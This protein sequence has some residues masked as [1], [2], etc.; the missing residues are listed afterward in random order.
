MI[1]KYLGLSLI[2]ASV[3]VMGCS[4]SDDGPST[5]GGTEPEVMLV[6]VPTTY[7]PTAIDP[8][9]T[10]SIAALATNTP[11]LSTLATAVVD[12]GLDTALD[13]ASSVF[14]V[15]APTNDAFALVEAGKLDGLTPEALAEVLNLHVVAGALDA[16]AV[17]GGVGMSVTTAEGTNLP[18]TADADGNLSIGGAPISATNIYATN[19]IVHLI[20]AVILPAETGGGDTSM[21]GGDDSMT[22][23]D[24]STT[25]GDAVGAGEAALEAAGNTSFIGAFE[26]IGLFNPQNFTDS[27][28]TIFAPTNDAIAAAGSVTKA[29]IDNHIYTNAAPLMAADFIDGSTLDMFGGG[30]YAVTNDGTTIT[31]GGFTVTEVY[32]GTAIIYSIDGVLQ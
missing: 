19:G 22:G 30:S 32:N 17:A 12:A 10:L 2:T 5:T 9:P 20:D 27:P 15:F 8:V 21:T 16:A 11:A 24:D 25:G 31:V 23:G 26:T 7:D 28:W 18:I 13:D 6:E 14:T 4:S 3:L 29:T 1:K